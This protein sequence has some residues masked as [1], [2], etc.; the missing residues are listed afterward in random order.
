LR[1]QYDNK[2]VTV[3]YY[4]VYSQQW[5]QCFNLEADLDFDG[6]LLLSGSSG[7]QD[8]DRIFLKSIKMYNPRE[9]ANNH[10]FEE[11]RA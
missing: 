9:V 3:S 5:S 7:L 1:I 2:L 8:P 4:D 11:S 6:Y 10:H